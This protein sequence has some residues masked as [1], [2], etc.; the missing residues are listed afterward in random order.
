MILNVFSPIIPTKHLGQK[1]DPSFHAV[2]YKPQYDNI[3]TNIAWITDSVM[4]VKVSIIDGMT[5]E[6]LKVPI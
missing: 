3:V 5:V 1:S 2:F 4:M 6:S